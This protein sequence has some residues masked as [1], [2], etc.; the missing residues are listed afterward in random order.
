MSDSTE[1]IRRE[2]VNELN[3]DPSSR[4]GLSHVHGKVWDTDEL[5]RDFEVTGFMAPFVVV[6]RKADGIVGSLEFQHHPRFYYNF[7]EDK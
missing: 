2:M 3:S 1:S 5:G 6:K 7:K 4:E